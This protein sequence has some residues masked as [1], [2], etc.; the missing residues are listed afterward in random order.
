M[1]D[2]NFDKLR[3][4]VAFMPIPNSAKREWLKLF[5]AMECIDQ[6]RERDI[7]NFADRMF[8]LEREHARHIRQNLALILINLCILWMAWAV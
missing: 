1:G 2:I 5:R 7:A 8:R 3:T 4:E 6:T